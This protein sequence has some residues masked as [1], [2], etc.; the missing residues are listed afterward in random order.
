VTLSPA[1]FKSQYGW[2]NEPWQVGLYQPGAENIER[3]YVNAAS[4]GPHDGKTWATAFSDLQDALSV[5][6]PNTEIWVAAGVYK[7]DRGTGARTASFHLKNGVRLLGGFAGIETSSDQR[8]PNN[9][10]TILS[11]DLK[12]DDGPDFAKNDENSYHVVTSL[13]NQ[14]EAVL[15]GF[16]ITGGNADGPEGGEHRFGGGMY[17]RGRPTIVDCVFKYNSAKESGGGMANLGADDWT[18]SGC[19]FI[20]NRVRNDEGEHA[21][22]GGLCNLG[23]N[24]IVDNCAFIN[25]FAAGIG[26]GAANGGGM[27]NEHCQVT[28]SRCSFIKNATD[29]RGGGMSFYATRGTIIKGCIFIGNSAEGYGGGGI[30]CDPASSEV[31]LTFANCVFIRNRASQGGGMIAWGGIRQTLVNCRFL[32]NSAEVGGGIYNIYGCSLVLSNC[33]F[34]GNSANSGG[35]IETGGGAKKSDVELMNCTLTKNFG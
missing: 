3:I 26:P 19:K 30:L 13:Y 14:P 17:N 7:P 12:G 35:A 8:D 24:L 32:G 16:T 23:S 27:Y 5:A 31:D 4:E 2:V 33:L 9:N 29:G 21:T 6:Q 1:D 10:E 28:V 18:L 15:Y 20:G 22:G 11:G 25:N 34:S